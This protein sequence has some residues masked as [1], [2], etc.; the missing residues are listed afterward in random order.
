MNIENS[1]ELAAY[2]RETGKVSVDEEIELK[3]LDGGVSNRTVL[4]KRATGEQWVLKQALVR[5][6]VASVWDCSTERLHQEA[7]ALRELPFLLPEG[8]VPAFIFEDTDVGVLAMSAVGSPHF[9][10][11]SILLHEGVEEKHVS[12]FARNLAFLH[13]RSRLKAKKYSRLFADRSF[14]EVLR[15]DAYYRHT[16]AAIPEASAFMHRLIK[17]T[18][19]CREALVHGDYSPKN[20]IIYQNELVL[21]DFEVVHWGDPAFD[22]GFALTHLLAKANHLPD[23]RDE[24]GA[25]AMQF[26]TRYAEICENRSTDREARVTRHTLACLLA[27]VAGKSPLEYLDEEEKTVQK[28]AVLTM[29]REPP[30]DVPGLIDSFIRQLEK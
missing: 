13:E 25:A 14:F 19:L 15:L 29:L 27:R 2:L 4:V 21:L 17:E 11:K 30:A 5:L 3:V 9:N 16:A 6:R 8:S 26:W 20:V 18:F 7:R 12:C 28:R 10:W 23:W 24:F 22:V 1:Q